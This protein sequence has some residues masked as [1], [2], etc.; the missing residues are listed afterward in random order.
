MRK[1]GTVSKIVPAARRG[2]SRCARNV[3][4]YEIQVPG[5]TAKAKPKTYWPVPSLL[6]RADAKAPLGAFCI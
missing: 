2:R 3:E 1:V 6:K 5:K 4:S